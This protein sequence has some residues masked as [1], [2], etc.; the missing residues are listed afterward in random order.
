MRFPQHHY[1]NQKLYVLVVFRERVINDQVI[2]VVVL[3]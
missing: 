2:V 3:L 1:E